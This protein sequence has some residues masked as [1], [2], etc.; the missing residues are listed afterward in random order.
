VKKS[1]L[2]KQTRLIRNEVV[3]RGDEATIAVINE[4]RPTG[5]PSQA[6][7][8]PHPKSAQ[9]GRDW[10]IGSRQNGEYIG[11]AR[12]FCNMQDMMMVHIVS[13]AG[14]RPTPGQAGC[15][16]LIRQSKAFTMICGHYPRATNNT[17][18]LRA[19]TEELRGLPEGINVWVSADSNYVKQGV[20]NWIQ[21]WKRSRSKNAKKG[22]VTNATLW[23]E[24]D[25]AIAPQARVAFTWVKAHSGIRLNEWADQLETRGVT[26]SSYSSAL[27]KPPEEAGSMEVFEM[28]DEDVTQWK[29]WD[30][31][32]QPPTSAVP[33]TSVGSAAEEQQ[34][35]QLKRFLPSRTSQT[36]G[37]AMEYAC[38]PP[39]PASSEVTLVS[40]GAPEDPDSDSMPIPDPDDS[41]VVQFVSGH[42]FQVCEDQIPEGPEE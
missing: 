1:S 12:E 23:R 30:D 38:S 40:D 19:V 22:H 36:L 14:V 42:G 27:E 3:F 41:G 15:G 34:D 13:D 24:L 2:T 35:E 39:R 8:R 9:D 20:M 7:P 6:P 25:S 29:D 21:K 28:T 16:A 4:P 33:V 18:A 32:E 11:N 5:V 31:D 17:M 26:G 37:Q 10:I